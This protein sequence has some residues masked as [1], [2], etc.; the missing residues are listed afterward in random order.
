MLKINK[1]DIALKNKNII[2]LLD[3]ISHFEGA[4]YNTIVGGK[5]FSDYSKH[6]QKEIWIKAINDYS[7]AAGRYQIIYPTWLWVSSEL[8]LKDFTPKSQDY[9][10][11]FLIE[12]KNQLQNAIDGK[13]DKVL[14]SISWIWAS[15]P[16]SRYGQTSNTTKKVVE[17][18][19]KKV[20]STPLKA[21][22]IF[23]LVLISI[24]IVIKVK[25]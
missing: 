8:G 20:D 11:L 10:A 5:T 15:L 22:Y 17:Y 18:F 3:T 14:E 4:N 16:P 24:I 9:A 19:K 2:A 23:W 1:Y 12:H 13:I 7:S 25:K 6:P 21:S